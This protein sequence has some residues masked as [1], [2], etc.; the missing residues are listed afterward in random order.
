MGYGKDED[1]EEEGEEVG[2]WRRKGKGTGKE[3]A[4]RVTTDFLRTHATVAGWPEKERARLK[5]LERHSVTL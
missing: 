3:I 4:L 1:G 5:R 2:H